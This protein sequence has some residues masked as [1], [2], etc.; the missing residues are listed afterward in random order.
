MRLIPTEGTEQQKDRMVKQFI[1]I[2]FLL[3][4]LAA[5]GATNQT[6]IF[7]DPNLEATVR[8]FIG[9]AKPGQPLT[10]AQLANAFLVSGSNASIHDLSGLEKC[11]NLNTI[12]LTGTQ[13]ADLTP[14][15]K[16]SN[17][18]Q[19]TIRNSK[20]RDLTPLA[21]LTHLTYLD[22]SSNQISNL[23]PLAK[24]KNLDTL[25]LSN[26]Q[27][28]DV[29]PLQGLSALQSLNL[30]GNQIGDLQPL[31]A[32]KSLETLNLKNNQVRDLTPLTNLT[33]WHSLYLDGNQIGDLAPL[34]VMAEKDEKGPK[35]FVQSWVLSLKGN[36]LSAS[37]RSHD[38]PELKKL[39]FD[40][41]ADK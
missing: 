32:L 25:N 11:P 8:K 30:S 22:L 39:A 28:A 19:L 33:G 20:I 40:V 23:G 36:P 3:S 38:L 10:Q 29:T 35:H 14:L 4:G 6:S 37:A 15:S 5:V 27:I 21:S 1:S 31:S 9:T 26:N 13:V 12:Y 34:V 7:K 41:A 17:L 16:L 24:L 2:T 18:Q